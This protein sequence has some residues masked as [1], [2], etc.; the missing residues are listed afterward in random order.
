[1][2]KIVQL[3]DRD[4]LDI[5]PIVVATATYMEDGVNVQQTITE[6]DTSINTILEGINTLLAEL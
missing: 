3:K 2:A 1:M 5:C 6:L 4:N